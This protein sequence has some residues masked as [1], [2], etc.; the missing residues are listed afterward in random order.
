[1]NAPL[2]KILPLW[3]GLQAIWEP[4][5]HLWLHAPSVSTILVQLQLA[6]PIQLQRP[7]LLLLEYLEG[8]SCGL[9]TSS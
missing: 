3:P 6:V 9:G 8:P 2:T 1:M 7:A 4:P 5:H